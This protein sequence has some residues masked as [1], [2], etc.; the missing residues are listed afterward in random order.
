MNIHDNMISIQPPGMARYN[1]IILQKTGNDAIRSTAM[2]MQ[3]TC[4]TESELS[5]HPDLDAEA[6]RTSD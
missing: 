5:A 3:P 4:E 6:D 1:L 2:W